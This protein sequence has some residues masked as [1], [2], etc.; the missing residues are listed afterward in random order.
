[1]S[2]NKDFLDLLQLLKIFRH[3]IAVLESRVETLYQEKDCLI[4]ERNR[5]R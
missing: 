4:R 1:M 5:L 2:V 3:E